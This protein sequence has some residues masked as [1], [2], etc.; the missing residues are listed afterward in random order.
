[1]K[2]TLE[3]HPL[4]RLVGAA[5]LDDTCGNLIMTYQENEPKEYR[6]PLVFKPRRTG[7]LGDLGVERFHAVTE[8][9]DGRRLGFGEV[10]LFA[11]ILGQIEEEHLRRF[12]VG[13][14]PRFLDEKLPFFV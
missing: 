4:T 8:I 13:I 9:P 5:T 14:A 2:S 3:Y 11:Q 10:V 1:M 12:F 7:V 6:G